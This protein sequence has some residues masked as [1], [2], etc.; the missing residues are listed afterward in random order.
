MFLDLAIPRDIDAEIGTLS[1]CEVKDL[2]YIKS[3]ATEN[4]RRKLSEAKKI[5]L[6]IEEHVDEMQK[7]LTFRT[8]VGTRKE[9]L[10]EKSAMWLL[11][12]LK[13][14]LDAQDL[15]HVLKGIEDHFKSC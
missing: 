6:L 4:N 11:Y 8:F 1:G 12:Q 10:G 15:N 2:D 9:K 5:E 3:L 7:L 14:V 13:D